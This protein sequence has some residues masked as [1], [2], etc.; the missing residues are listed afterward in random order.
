MRMAGHAQCH[1]APIVSG[2]AVFSVDIR[3]NSLSIPS[4]LEVAVLPTSR[5]LCTLVSESLTGTVIDSTML[6]NLTMFRRWNGVGIRGE[7]ML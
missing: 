1:A 6:S 4:L 5:N 7:H 3:F 2:S